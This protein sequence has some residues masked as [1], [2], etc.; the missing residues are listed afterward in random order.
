MDKYS[1]TDIFRKY[2]NGDLIEL[3]TYEADFNYNILCYQRIGQHGIADYDAVLSQTKP[4][5]G[6][7]YKSL[8]NEL[9]RCF[10]YDITVLKRVNRDSMSQAWRA[11]HLSRGNYER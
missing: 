6:K 8:F 3:F 4:A 1:L 9:T 11:L 7:E 10:N 2:E 5:T